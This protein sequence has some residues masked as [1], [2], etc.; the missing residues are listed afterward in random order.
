MPEICCRGECGIVH[1]K[2]IDRF[3]RLFFQKG[4]NFLQDTLSK[5]YKEGSL[6]SF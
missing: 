4:K 6:L 1:L 2:E 3:L 5:G